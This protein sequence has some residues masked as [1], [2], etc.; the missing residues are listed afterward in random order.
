MKWQKKGLI[1]KA[2]NEYGWICS[3]A[4]IPTVLVMEDRLRVYFATRPKPGMSY[5]AMMDLDIDNPQ[6]IIKIYENPVLL[7]GMPGEFDEHG[8]MPNWV[9]KKENIVYLIYVGWS[10]R[11]EI[12]YSNWQGIAVSYDDGRT[13]KKCFPGPILDRT[14]NEILS[15]TGLFVVAKDNIY[16]GFYANGTKWYEVDGKLESAYEIVTTQSDDLINWRSRTGIPILKTKIPNEANTRPTIIEFDD[17]YHMWFCYRGVE[18]YRD[19]ENSYTIGYASSQDLLHWKRDDE[20]SGIQKSK[21]GWDSKM[22]AYPYV[23]RVKD[24][25][26][27]FYNGNGFG[28]AGFGYAQL[29]DE[30]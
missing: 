12:P 20:K 5:I 26:Y 22:M 16:Y 1:F 19:G 29:V 15:A 4:Q 3:H 6:K 13:F 27:M 17:Y 21:Y 2:G 11:E 25:V 30:E 10:R 23:V 24:K 18:D 9:Y 8:V 7:P 28:R 14:K